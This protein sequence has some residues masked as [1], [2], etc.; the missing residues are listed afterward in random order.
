MRPRRTSK[1]LIEP[2]A[3]ATGDIAFNLIVF[4]LVCASSEPDSG[5]RQ[6]LPSS[7]KTKQEQKTDNIEISLTR[8]RNVVTVNGD[9]VR[10]EELE[11]RLRRLLTGK[12]RPE[13]RVVVVR[14]KPDTPYEHWIEVTAL[15]QDLGASITIQREVERTVNVGP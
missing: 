11:G 1:F 13:D 4:F 6:D 12:R 5:R 8:T 15:V 14:S 2:A 3:V 7:E 10:F 9:P